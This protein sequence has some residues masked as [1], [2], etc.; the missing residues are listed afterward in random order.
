IAAPASPAARAVASGVAERLGVSLLDLAGDPAVLA[1]TLHAALREHR[2]HVPGLVARAAAGEVDLAA[3]VMVLAAAS[4]A[5]ILDREASGRPGSL[6][7]RLAVEEP[8]AAEA[9]S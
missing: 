4:G 7:V 5:V 3:E 6:T 1:D 2:E 8:I 9:A